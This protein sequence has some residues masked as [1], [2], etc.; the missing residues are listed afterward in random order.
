MRGADR[1]RSPVFCEH[2]KTSLRVS[3]SLPKSKTLAAKK[4]ANVTAAKAPKSL[5]SR[6][7]PANMAPSEFRKIG[8]TL[9]DSIAD[10]LERIPEVPTAAPL[11]PDAMRK[12][13]GKHAMPK[14]G[15][16]I[17]PVL[18]KFTEKFFKYSTH[19][20][21]PRFFGYITPS[22]APISALADLL[23]ASVN[24]NCGAWAL[25]PVATETEN[26]CI[27]WLSEFLGLPGKWT[28]VLVSGGNMANI[29]PFIAARRAKAPWDIQT[30]GI[31]ADRSKRLVL[32]TSAE[33]HGWVKKAADICGLG[34]DSIRWIP[35]DS[36]LRMRTDAL[37][38]QI[39]ADRAADLFPFLVIGTAGSVGT[40]ATD[41]LPEIA[42]ICKQF[43]LWFHVDG[44]YGAPAVA[45]DDASADLKG[46]RL[47]DSIAMDP[48]KW[49][50]ASLE[51]GCVL[52]RD[53]DAL[54][55]AFE[56]KAPYYQFDDNEGQEVTNFYDY[57]PQNSRNFRAL[58]I[59]L[60]FQQSGANGYR[61][62]ISDDIALAHQM[63][64]LV[65]EE[66]FLEQGTVALSICTFRFVPTDLRPRLAEPAVGEYINS[67]NERLVTAVR[68]SGEAFVSNAHI[69]D[70]YMIRA[71]IVNFRTTLPDVAAVPK[72]VV[73]LG[74]DLDKKLRPKALLSPR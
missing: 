43:D 40:G 66:N 9:V 13:V 45:L 64:D 7:A 19:N 73:R 59:W 25:S 26:E 6:A 11:L 27:R 63:H 72:L 54:Q 61:Q 17:G 10:F 58:K 74:K 5:K 67:L 62:M 52:V 68:L 55:N 70:K 39:T 34:T 21:S 71:C 31:N 38:E 12:V 48:H 18:E 29:V 65:G 23:A 32:Y 50:Y 16:E 8:H 22:A 57:G 46:L 28:G 42:R 35:T 51:A 20:G 2:P 3:E 37:R 49:L 1:D 30:K 24:P 14:T 56:F 60:G 47:A 41:P 33:T 36:G 15:T 4:P 44:A 69:G 53:P